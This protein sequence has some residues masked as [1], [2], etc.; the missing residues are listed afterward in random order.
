M[1]TSPKSLRVKLLSD[2]KIESG[3]SSNGFRGQEERESNEERERLVSHVL[4]C[5]LW[6]SMPRLTTVRILV[7]VLVVDLLLVSVGCS[8]I[9]FI[10]PLPSATS[11]QE[12]PCPSALY[13]VHISGKTVLKR[14]AEK[15]SV[16]QVFRS[17]RTGTTDT[18]AAPACVLNIV[19]NIGTGCIQ[20]R[21]TWNGR[22]T[23]S[24][25]HILLLP[26]RRKAMETREPRAPNYLWPCVIFPF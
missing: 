7:H 2:T 8:H 24:T 1:T 6:H 5:I 21:I 3:I 11:V 4:R 23:V 14:S 25:V 26:G 9:V 13:S 15:R 19:A 20:K 10:V 16:L 12:T 22:G 17:F 18:D